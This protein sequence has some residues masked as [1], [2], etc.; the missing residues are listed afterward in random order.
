M[1]NKI[2]A[3]TLFAAVSAL[4]GCATSSSDPVTPV[5]PIA[6]IPK[7]QISGEASYRERIALQSGA[8]F[9]VQLLDI[10]R[11]DA[12]S[13]M[14]A[15]ERRVLTGEQVPLPFMMVVPQNKL[16]TNMRYAM[17]ATISN[18]SG[19]LAWTTDTVH[20]VDPEQRIQNLGT[21]MMVRVNQSQETPAGLTGQ[22]WNVQNID[23]T[24]V[25]DSAYVFVTFT[26][27]GKVSGSSGCN[28]FNGTYTNVDHRIKI[29]ALAS[30]RKAC[31]PALD[32]QE[33]R[34][35]STFQNVTNW[36]VD[37]SNRVI[38]RTDGGQY[39]VLSQAPA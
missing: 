10:S 24:A 14:I 34:F 39:I 5:H 15:Q 8:I 30:T 18:P 28:N 32:M 29:N 4:G 22:Q 1:T 17:R 13:E 26:A 16:K 21:M 23:G 9:D 3:L 11:A 31:T 27:D 19:Q 36:A 25:I 37:Q 38:M 6:E 33:G 20:S 2:I 35:L 7:L 12:P